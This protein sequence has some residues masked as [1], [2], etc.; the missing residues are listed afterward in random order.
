MQGTPNQVM[1]YA[2]GHTFGAKV[3]VED[4]AGTETQP[5]QPACISPSGRRFYPMT[6][7]QQEQQPD[8]SLLFHLSEAAC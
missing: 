8:C 7:D 4:E 5:D 1:L 6:F 3:L 2:G